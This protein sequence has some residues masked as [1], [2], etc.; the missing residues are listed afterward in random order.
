MKTTDIAKNFTDTI[1]KNYTIRDAQKPGIERSLVITASLFTCL[2]LLSVTAFGAYTLLPAKVHY[3][4]SKTFLISQEINKAQVF[5][6]LLLPTSGS[7][8]AVNNVSVQWEG[9]QETS[10]RAYVDLL[11]L[12][13]TLPGKSEKM[14]VVEYDVILPQGAVSW[15][16]PVDRF[17]LLPQEGIESNN[18]DIK[19][20]ANSITND[21][22]QNPAYKIYKFTSSYLDY[23][24]TGCEDTN[25]S[26]L[27]AFHT[28]VG[29][30]IAYSRLM[31]ALCRGSEIPAKMV[32]GTVMPDI[33]YSF[34]QTVTTCT[35]GNG[36]AWVEYSTQDSWHLA[37]PCS[38]QGFLAFLAFNRNDGRHLS[39]GDF[40]HFT[41]SKD[42]IFNWATESA[43]P[44]DNQL[45]FVFASSSE[46]TSITTETTIK[47]TWDQRWLNVILA[48]G[49]VAFILCKVRDWILSKY[50]PA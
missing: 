28:K 12:W 13:G 47:K 48:L 3:H 17:D 37:D 24:K 25:I 16:S 49:G 18:P 2:T 50:F 19:K 22:D 20:T 34:P 15:R 38:Y 21:A 27:E 11:K 31:V 39:F 36:H 45:T 8:Q 29:T 9:N 46:N 10:S 42:E 33:L 7:Y 1:V 44:K 4:V 30:C 23:S 40:G 14:A 41:K 6:G 32:I 5:L 26:A 35:P 43:Q